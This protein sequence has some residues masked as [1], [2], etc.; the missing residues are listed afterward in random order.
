MRWIA[1]RAVFTLCFILGSTAWYILAQKG[2]TP[3]QPIQFTVETPINQAIAQPRSEQQDDAPG[4]SIKF[5]PLEP[6]NGSAN[7]EI[8]ILRESAD[9]N[10]PV[11]AK[12]KVADYEQAVILGATSDFLHVR[13]AANGDAVE[14]SSGREHD[15]EGWTTWDSVVM[16]L[17]AIVLDA[18]SGAVVSRVPLRDGLYSI[19]FSQDG[20]RGLFFHDSDGIGSVAYEVRTSDYTL[21]RSLTSADEEYLGTLFYGPANGELYAGVQTSDGSVPRKGKVSL[22][23]IGEEGTSSI[24]AELNLTQ[25][26]FAVSRDGLTGFITRPQNGDLQELTVDVIDLA[27]QKLRNTFTLSGANFPSDSSNF[28]LN[29]DGSELY[30]RFSDNPGVI[31]VID[32]R[33]GLV[34]RELVDSTKNGESY[35]GRESLVGDSLLLRVWEGN[36]DE[37]HDSPHRYWLGANGRVAA[38][39]G[40]DYAIEAGGK[41]YA[42]NE[43]GTRFFKLDANN[44]I[45][46]RLTIARPELRKGASASDSLSVFGLAASPDGKRIIIFIGIMSGC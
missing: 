18:E 11:V 13:F 21:T 2:S 36:E 32:T 28:V 26:N 39:H 12:L 43:K 3:A 38:E 46:E 45:R 24:A 20:S 31:S 33:S 5:G 44:H 41:R 1:R 34:V 42:V 10:A 19:A 7:T 4:P 23:R 14:G 40:I 9:A 17:S 16:E 22:V 29:R 37:M 35:F 25:S 15:Y 6:M 30:S 8:V 27:T